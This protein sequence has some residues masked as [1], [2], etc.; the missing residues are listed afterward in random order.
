MTADEE[1]VPIYTPEEVEARRHAERNQMILLG[2]IVASIT[3]NV[4]AL[5]T[6]VAR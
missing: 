4:L 6:V 2:S 5:L 1:T 3:M